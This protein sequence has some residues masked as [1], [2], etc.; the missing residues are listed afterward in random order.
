MNDNSALAVVEATFI[1]PIIFLTF[2][3]VVLVSIYLPSRAALQ[4]ATQFAATALATQ[5]SDT[6]IYFD[7][8]TM[9]FRL[10]TQKSNVYVDFV[11]SINFWSRG[12]RDGIQNR[13]EIIVTTLEPN[14]FHITQPGELKVS[15]TVRN[16]VVYREIVVT[17]T[18]II[19]VPID[20]PIIDFPLE[21]PITATSTAVIKNSDEFVRSMDILV[22]LFNR[23]LTE[24]VRDS[25][26]NV[27]GRVDGVMGWDD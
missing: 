13:A 10:L 12:I 18:R 2:A 6:W 23:F 26:N 5:E 17:A 24:S 25:I 1:L 27:V 4:H 20:L 22:D 9:E 3:G 8:N 19:R 16:F 7:E 11:R 15:T 21:I 14:S